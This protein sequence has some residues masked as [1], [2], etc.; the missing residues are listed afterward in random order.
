M[1]EIFS[2]F[3]QKM[4]VTQDSVK[5]LFVPTFPITDNKKGNEV[6]GGGGGETN[7][8]NKRGT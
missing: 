4:L 3:V 7:R 2:R 8:Q 1:A 6:G 5:Y